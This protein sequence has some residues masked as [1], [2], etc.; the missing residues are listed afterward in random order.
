MTAVIAA[1]SVRRQRDTLEPETAERL[2]AVVADPNETTWN[3]A[4]SRILDR[5]WSITLWNAVCAI[6]PTFPDHR[7]TSNWPKIPTQR[8]IV[9]AIEAVLAGR[10]T[11]N[12]PATAGSTTP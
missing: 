7:S 8:V 9:L 1:M 11:R 12:Q 6:D 10:I 2:R 3:A 4:Y 5:T